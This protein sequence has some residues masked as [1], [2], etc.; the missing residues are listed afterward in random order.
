MAHWIFCCRYWCVS[1]ILA[2]LRNEGRIFRTWIEKTIN[3]FM[4]SLIIVNYGLSIAFYFQA[5][6]Q[7][8]TKEKTTFI[9]VPIAFVVINLI[10]ITIAVFRVW[11]IL[12]AE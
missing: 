4:F 9:W 12:R 11:A 3:L 2:D 7:Y 8:N 5:N 6:G 10:V 1:E